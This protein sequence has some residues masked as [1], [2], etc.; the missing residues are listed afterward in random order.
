MGRERACESPASVQAP[1]TLPCISTLHDWNRIRQFIHHGFHIEADH[2]TG[3]RCGSHVSHDLARR[4]VC[5]RE[6]GP[7]GMVDH[8]GSSIGFTLVGPM[9]NPP[10]FLFASSGWS[11]SC[12]RSLPNRPYSRCVLLYSGAHTECIGAASLPWSAP[13][14][15]TSRSVPR[16]AY[17]FREGGAL[18]HVLTNIG[19]KR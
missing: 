9:L 6:T 7:R 8:H 17:R 3:Q 10:R 18:K 19:R 14:G 16:T 5:S 11:A 15:N 4:V 12:P 2:R 1:G 13:F